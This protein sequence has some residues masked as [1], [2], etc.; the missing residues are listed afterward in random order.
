MSDDQQKAKQQQTTIAP[1]LSVRNGVRA[2]EFYQA[3]FG[4]DELFRIQSDDGAVVARLSVAGAEF[5]LADE[6]PEH[7][8]FSPE[9]LSGGTVRMVLT[10]ENPDAAFERAVTAGAT[11]IWPVSDQYGWRLG[12]IVDPFGHHWEIGKPLSEDQ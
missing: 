9:T 1:M 2:I 8:N 11:V 7:L 6:S 4:A 5:W 10:V 12:R 3:A